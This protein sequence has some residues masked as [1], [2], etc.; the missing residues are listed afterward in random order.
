VAEERLVGGHGNAVGGFLQ[1]ETDGPAFAF[2]VR[3]RGG[4]VGIDEAD[5]ARG[6][7]GAV[8]SGA[9]GPR[10]AV[11]LG[12][13]MCSASDDSPYPHISGPDAGA[14]C[15]GRVERLQNQRAR[16]FAKN[17]AVPGGVKRPA[18]L[19]RSGFLDITP[20]LFHAPKTNGSK[21]ESAP[22]HKTRLA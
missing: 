10:L 12:V 14:A 1:S 11:A 20:R 3:P 17:A 21:T 2:V 13:V 6:H 9:D 7:A 18:C 16:A 8:Q 22:P 5:V 4:A 19:G 15:P